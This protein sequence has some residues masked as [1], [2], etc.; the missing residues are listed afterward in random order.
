MNKDKY[1]QMGK[2]DLIGFASPVE[3][4]GLP[5]FIYDWFADLPTQKNHKLAFLLL[6]Y[7]NI[8]GTA[9]IQFRTLVQ[10]KGFRII[11]GHTLHMPDNFP[12]SRIKGFK[13][14][15]SPNKQELSRF[16][17]FASILKDLIESVKAGHE[18]L[19]ASFRLSLMNYFFNIPDRYAAKRSIG[20]KFVN[21]EICTSCS[22]CAKECPYNA[23][24][25]NCFPIFIEEL[26]YGCWRCYN[27]CPVQAIYTNKLKRKGHYHGPNDI[28]LEKFET[29]KLIST[30]TK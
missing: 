3:F 29:I 18:I 21:E 20:F 28:L 30:K 8:A 16:H 17:L 26:C 4:F 5:K 6:T 7:G 1:P 23:I 13:A 10:E 22:L 15:S 2:Y 27:I 25:M 12:I 19:E 14:S 11:A 24:E 9:I